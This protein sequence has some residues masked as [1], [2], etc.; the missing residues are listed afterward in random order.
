[1]G[2]AN[3]LSSDVAAAVLA[4]KDKEQAGKNE[5]IEIVRNFHSALRD[6]TGE[7]RQRRRAHTSSSSESRQAN[8]RAASGHH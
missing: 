6:L 1:M 4:R 8:T 5:L 2:I 3:E 7:E